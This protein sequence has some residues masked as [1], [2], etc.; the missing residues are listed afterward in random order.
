MKKRNVILIVNRGDILFLEPLSI[1]LE[2]NHHLIKYIYTT[3]F[4]TSKKIEY[5][6]ANL[7]IAKF[8]YLIRYTAKTIINKILILLPLSDKIKIKLSLKKL[9]KYYSIP[10]NPVKNINSKEFIIELSNQNANVVLSTTS[11]I[12]RKQIL[13]IENLK[14]YNIHPSIL[15][16]NK[17]RFPIFWAIINGNKQGITCHQINN[18]I[19]N[20]AIVHQ[21]YINNTKHKTVEEVMHIILDYM[22]AF[23]DESLQII[24]NDNIRF[25][26]PKYKPFYGP[27]PNKHDI[28][29]YHEILK[30][31]H[32][33]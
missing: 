29:Y 28:K 33:H 3:S 27:I 13:N 25:I 7:R 32:D 12:Y 21:I 6:L 15:P 18:K 23:M 8:Q 22:P 1:F 9:A 24:L 30:E 10:I 26:E 5:I 14:F 17:G 16:M 20:G 11:Q 4:L 31:Q 19:D 2:K